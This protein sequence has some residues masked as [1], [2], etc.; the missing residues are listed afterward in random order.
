MLLM[1]ESSAESSLS[2]SQQQ[3]HRFPFSRKPQKT[4]TATSTTMAA[5]AIATYSTLQPFGAGAGV[6]IGVADNETTPRSSSVELGKLYNSCAASLFPG[7]NTIS[8]FDIP[9]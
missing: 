2:S 7:W 4:A 9:G 8:I 1:A 5:A 3:L 6:A